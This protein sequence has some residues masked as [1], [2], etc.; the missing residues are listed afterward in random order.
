MP[1]EIKELPS[2]TRLGE[3]FE[4]DSCN[5]RIWWRPRGRDEFACYRL[6]R[7]FN[8]QY[9]GREAGYVR[10]GYWEVKYKGEKYAVHRIIYQ[11]VNNVVLGVKEVDHIDGDGLNNRPGNLRMATDVQNAQNRKC[12]S[13]NKLLIKGVQAE[14]YC[15]KYRARIWINGKRIHLGMYKTPEEAHAAYAK[16][17]REL[18]GEF[19]R[20]A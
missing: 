8:A 19:G 14:L 11:L 4:V 2:L 10:D 13:N 7:S 20:A 16:A 18:H 1:S 3:L 9:A 5:G 15:A 17:S 6:W 12:P